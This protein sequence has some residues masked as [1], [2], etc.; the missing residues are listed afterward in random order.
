MAD[1]G[2]SADP[3]ETAGGEFSP[4]ELDRLEDALDA[5]TGGLDEPVPEDSSLTPALRA[6]L[7]DY[8]GLLTLAR[9]AMP[10]QDVSDDLLAGVLAEAHAA[11]PVRGARRATLTSEA[12][13]SLWE[14]LRRSMLL[15]GVAL[16]GSAALL[17]WM[18]Q[19]G[20]DAPTTIANSD[21]PTSEATAP[22]RLA[23]MPTP[24]PAAS[25]PAEV[26]DVDRGAV[27]RAA[28]DGA[29][30]GAAPAAMPGAAAPP[31]DAR[32]ENVKDMDE[33]RADR[34]PRPSKKAEEAL[35]PEAPL[36]GLDDAPPADSDKEAL[37]D[38]LD[39]ADA[40]RRSNQCDRAMTLYLQ[41]FDMSGPASER[42]QA[43]GGY[44]LCLQA[45]GK[46]GDAQKYFDFAA[47]LSSSIDSWIKR[48]RGE[49]S[50]SKKAARPSKSPPK[51]P[52]A[53]PLK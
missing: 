26:A 39:E 48:E 37:R 31:A 42:A 24:S 52:V 46:D 15:P 33:A 30:G 32:A 16:A 7:A 14:R 3:G 51:K 45:Q 2:N 4:A 9:D 11:A 29:L 50:Y 36:P 19:P 41:A 43:R 47:K 13:P 44:G 18:V 10:L 38:T 40:L 35:E 1:P 25:M 27:D 49:G 21:F 12:G 53:E 17:L 8:R 28:S 20:D 5:W 34:K 6:R 23:P 22:A